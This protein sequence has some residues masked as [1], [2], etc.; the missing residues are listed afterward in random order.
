MTWSHHL[1]GEVQANCLRRTYCG[2]SLFLRSQAGLKMSC[3][4][5]R[6]ETICARGVNGC[7]GTPLREELDGKKLHKVLGGE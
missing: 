7:Q 5:R 2:Q 3:H 6:H 1:A 4:Q